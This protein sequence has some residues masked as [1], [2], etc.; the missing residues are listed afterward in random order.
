M[1]WKKLKPSNTAQKWGWGIAIFSVL[2][3]VNG[4]ALGIIETSI[5]YFLLIFVGVYFIVSPKP[6]EFLDKRRQKKAEQA[7]SAIQYALTKLEKAS[8]VQAAM[9][10]EDLVEIVNKSQMNSSEKLSELLKSINFDKSRVESRFL[11][12]IANLGAPLFKSAKK[13]TIRI[14]ED[15]VIAGELGFN[16]DVS[17]RGSVTVDGSIQLDKNNKKVDMRTATLQLATQDW[18][19][20]FKIFP[21]QA[22][23]ARRILN[24]L[25]AIVE[26]KKPKGVT[27]TDIQE[28]MAKLVS[29]TGKSP[30]E[31]LEELSNLRYQRLLTDAEF[32]SAKSKILSL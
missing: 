12:S 14:Y 29:N 13:S 19:H 20:A 4:F 7:E 5:F 21:D 6:Q 18:S 15:W 11:G 8:G 23:E 1:D 26:E 32:E 30:A 22:D 2:G 9:A 16:F 3:V 28:A 31:K 17:T 25:L 10:Y 24:Q 27:A